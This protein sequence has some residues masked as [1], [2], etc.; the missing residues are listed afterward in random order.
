[1]TAPLPCWSR[2]DGPGPAMH[3]L[4]IGTS[5]YPYRPLGL[6]DL[7]GAATSAD[8]FARWLRDRY[9]GEGRRVGSIR[10]L[11]AP[12][13]AERTRVSAGPD[14]PVPDR[15]TVHRAVH[16]WSRD[17]M[18]SADNVA[19]LYVCGHGLQETDDGALVF[20]HDAG[21]VPDDPLDGA[22]DVAGIRSGMTGTT[23]PRR[24][25]YFADACR[26]PSPLL[27]DFEGPLRGGITLKLR[28]GARPAH[29]PVFFAAE[30][31]GLSW[32]SWEG[33]TFM[34]ALRECLDL[35]AL[36]PLGDAKGGWGVTAQSL[37]TALRARV[38]ELAQQGG[39]WQGVT[40]GGSMTD[41][42]LIECDPPMVPVTLLVTPPEAARAT[43]V[44]AEIFDGNTTVRV[45]QRRPLPLADIPIAAGV[46]TLSVTFDPPCPPYVDKPA[47]GLYVRPPRVD[48]PVALR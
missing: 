34:R 9:P 12:A 11:L 30:P 27:D 8:M 26:V 18:A 35:L 6:T 39:E 47:I 14:V 20:V 41:A 46:W 29:R 48:Q 44:G 5:T 19:V 16:E 40:V 4:V 24:Q 21:S 37:L 28:R 13:E 3:A 2:N 42:A 43:G 23:G 32:Q 7:P 22:L 33:S 10:L 31:G 25:W 36:V 1:V 17:C 38:A 15:A 45:L